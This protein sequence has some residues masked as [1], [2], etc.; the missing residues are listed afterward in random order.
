V[1]KGTGGAEVWQFSVDKAGDA[2]ASGQKIVSHLAYNLWQ[3][4]LSPDGQW[5][6]L[7]AVDPEPKNEEPII[8]V[9]PHTGGPWVR[10]TEKNHWFLECLAVR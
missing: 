4:R 10:I 5:I 9:T 6:L 8:F 3:P 2:E 7:Q 1:V